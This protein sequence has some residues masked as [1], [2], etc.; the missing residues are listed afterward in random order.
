MP[1]IPIDQ[2]GR[3]GLVRDMKPH[4]LPL[5]A[6]TDMQNMRARGRFMERFLGQTQVFG[7]PTVAPY[8]LL[9]APAGT[10]NRWVYAGLTKIYGVD[11]AASPVHTDLSRAG[12]YSASAEGN[13]TGGILGEVAI[14]NNG[15]DPP[16]FWLPVSAMGTDFADLTNWPASTTCNAMRV[17]K[18]YLVAIDVT[19]SGTRYPQM[20]K[21]SH[22]ADPRTVPVSWDETD[23]IRDAGEYTLSESPGFALDCLPLR[24][25]NIVYKEDCIWGM[26]YI[27]G[28]HIF[29]FFKIFDFGMR[30]R[31]AVTHVPP[32]RHMV[33]TGDDLIVHDGQT[34]Q[35]LMTDRDR[36][37]MNTLMNLVYQNRFFCCTNWRFNEAWFCF[38][39]GTPASGFEFPNKAYVWN[40]QDNTLTLRDLPTISHAIDTPV[41]YT[42]SGDTWASDNAPWSSDMTP[43][44]DRGFTGAFRQ[45]L[46]A[47]PSN[48]KLYHADQGTTWNGTGYDSMLERVGMG[49][50]LEVNAPPDI[51]RSKVLK[52]VWPRLTGPTGQS[53]NIYVGS[54]REVEAPVVWQ[55]PFPFV[56]GSQKK[57]NPLLS[58][59]LF[60][61]RYASTGTFTWQLHGHEFNVEPGGRY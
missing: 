21:W 13:W 56:I 36:T 40:W 14:L 19:K 50:P 27:G 39:S 47:S 59:K 51:T 16:Q 57:I 35:S 15:A 20:V 30:V 53:I 44:G 23:P 3:F 61:I 52:E 46:L 5:N 41:V 54:Q 48:V 26:Q 29:R 33:F 31:R 34:Y 4:E 49:I 42:A 22:P 43:W 37:Q 28:V 6:W 38:V 8:S 45:L 25:L 11:D 17:F 12:N 24:D 2:L 1:I 10:A 58:G 32:G 55:G 60:S 9:Y 7:T 18:Q